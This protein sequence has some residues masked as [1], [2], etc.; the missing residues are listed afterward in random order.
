MT[1]LSFKFVVDG[2]NT[3]DNLQKVAVEYW[4]PLE[5]LYLDES[6]RR[7]KIARTCKVQ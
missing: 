4:K 5:G 1:V 7:I 6:L 2:V 3:A